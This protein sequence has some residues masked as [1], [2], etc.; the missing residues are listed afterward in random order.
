LGPVQPSLPLL[1]VGVA[2]GWQAS[3]TQTTWEVVGRGWEMV[4]PLEVPLFQPLG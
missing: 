3:P 4:V 2:T 1:G